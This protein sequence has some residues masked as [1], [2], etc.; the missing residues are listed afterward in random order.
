V[1]VPAAS[2]RW[3]GVGVPREHGQMRIT[4]DDGVELEVE[5]NGHGPALMLVHGFGGAKEDWA[6]HTER[7]GADQTVI[8][9]DHRGHGASDK[10]DDPASYSLER[11]MA[12]VGNVADALEL[13]RFRLLGHSMGGMVSRKYAIANPDRLEALVMMDTCG[14][15]IPGFDPEL[16]ELAAEVALTRGKDNLKELL[17]MAPVLDTP[18][19]QRT[20][21]ERP[22]YEEFTARK[23]ADVSAVMWGA[24]AIAMSR[25]SDDLAA[26]ARLAFP[27]LILVG[28]QDTPMVVASDAMHEAMPDS[29]LVVIPDAGHS[30][31]FENPEAWYEALSSFLT[32]LPAAGGSLVA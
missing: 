1:A 13:G 6:D 2:V 9:F 14:A 16:M 3:R 5:M 8:V 20:L 19:Y 18:A 29:R 11:L 7:L 17:D 21:L 32:S 23:W 24:M 12:D 4:T 26:M 28:E 27:V 25:Q 31:Q 15:P 22:G 30:P 10:P